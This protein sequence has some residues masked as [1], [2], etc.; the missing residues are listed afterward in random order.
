MV[1]AGLEG[2]EVFALHLGPLLPES[3]SRE[4]VG[5][6]SLI[7][8][9]PGFRRGLG[10][11]AERQDPGRL[12]QA[13]DPGR[14]E[15]GPPAGR[16]LKE[17]RGPSRTV[18][19]SGLLSEASADV[20]PTPSPPAPPRL[21]YPPSARSQTAHLAPPSC[22]CEGWGDRSWLRCHRGLALLL[23]IRAHPRTGRVWRRLVRRPPSR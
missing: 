5:G 18:S 3:A 19:V 17:Q 13:V 15:G 4:G 11:V 16:G 2:L 22:P 1:L 14:E 6:Q 21:V 20:A 12:A 8:I 7:D 23:G 10:T 9:V